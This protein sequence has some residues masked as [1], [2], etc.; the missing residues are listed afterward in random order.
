MYISIGSKAGQDVSLPKNIPFR[1]SFEEANDFTGKIYTKL[2]ELEKISQT[3]KKLG[4]VYTSGFPQFKHQTFAEW[5]APTVTTKYTFRQN[6]Y[7][8]SSVNNPN[9]IDSL[10]WEDTV[11]DFIYFVIADNAKKD[12]YY[13][14]GNYGE[15]TAA[16]SK[17]PLI[18]TTKFSPSKPP[19][20]PDAVTTPSI[21]TFDR[22]SGRTWFYDSS[23][24][25]DDE[26]KFPELKRA[27]IVRFAIARYINTT[28]GWSGQWLPLNA[29]TADAILSLPEALE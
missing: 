24:V 20:A 28:S 15:I 8:N 25:Q 17:T 22:T 13:Y 1:T 18:G 19:N 7:I 29:K 16:S 4:L 12:D 23:P 27:I 26:E 21:K 2:K 11:R 9:V 10:I 6:N 5:K 3:E 14:F